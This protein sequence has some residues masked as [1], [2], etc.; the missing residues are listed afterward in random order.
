MLRGDHGGEKDCNAAN[1]SCVSAL[2]V[3][4]TGSSFVIYSD[5]R[6]I[7]SKVI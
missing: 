2:C 1:A 6:G 4:S 7:D 3:V 5:R